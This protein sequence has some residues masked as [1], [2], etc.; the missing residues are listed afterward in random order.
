ME[1]I[2]Y[3]VTYVCQDS[4]TDFYPETFNRFLKDRKELSNFIIEIESKK[5]LKLVQVYTCN[6]F[7]LEKESVDVIVEKYK[8]SLLA[9]EQLREKRR[10]EALAKLTEED[11]QLLGVK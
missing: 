2:K 5:K 6:F 11:K 7:P 4:S 10:K 8:E 3:C 9:E 1:D